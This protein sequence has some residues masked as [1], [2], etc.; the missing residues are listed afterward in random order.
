M[1]RAHRRSTAFSLIELLVVVFIIGVLLALLLPAVQNAR[2]SARRTQ[3]A[4]NLRQIALATHNYHERFGALPM[5][6]PT[7]RYA[8]AGVFYGPSIFVALLADLERRDLYD[9]INFQS[10]IYTFSNQ[11]A[12]ETA[13]DVLWCPSDAAIVESRII[14][15][16]YLDIPYGLFRTA[17]SSYAA[18]SGT[19]FHS[20]TNLAALPGLTAQDNGVAYVNSAVRFAQITDGLAQTILLGERAHGRLSPDEQLVW[21]W[22]FDG[23]GGD[24]LFWT[25]YPINL[26]RSPGSPSGG[27]DLINPY[28]SSAGS[29]HPGSANFAFADG[30]VRF[31]KDSIDTWRRSSST[32]FP[33]GLSGSPDSPYELA[34]GFRFGVYQALSTRNGNEVIDM[35]AF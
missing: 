6:S 15:R 28:P 20:T 1:P 10:N 12:H 18:C 35:N 16:D 5:G 22:W 11:T 29:F 23:Y 33:I 19:W 24:T 26:E 13:L 4:N 31:L 8:D 27:H 7:A 9:S 2:E 3:C 34:P 25:L 14:P 32:G 17:Y 30:S 21:H